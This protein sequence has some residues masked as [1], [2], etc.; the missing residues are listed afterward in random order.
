M[1]QG[2][3]LCLQSNLPSLPSARPRV[4]ALP[5]SAPRTMQSSVGQH[6][7]HIESWHVVQNLGLVRLH[8]PVLFLCYL[9]NVYLEGGDRV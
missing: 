8:V 5:N 9:R 7:S 3:V 2:V 1:I 4:N 6:Q